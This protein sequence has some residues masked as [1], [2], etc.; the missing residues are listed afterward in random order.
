M[1]ANYE[2]REPCIGDRFDNIEVDP[3]VEP[4]DQSDYRPSQGRSNWI[5]ARADRGAAVGNKGDGTAA[6]GGPSLREEW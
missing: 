6:K 5:R 4:P 1:R 3:R 2:E